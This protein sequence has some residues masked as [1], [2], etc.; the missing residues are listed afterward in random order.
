MAVNSLVHEVTKPPPSGL[1][2]SA[3]N[4]MVTDIEGMRLDR[5]LDLGCGL[6][7][8]DIAGVIWVPFQYKYHIS[9][10]SDSYF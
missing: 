6:S 3:E 5:V 4:F 10:C 9:R 1:S 8:V 2:L 7:A